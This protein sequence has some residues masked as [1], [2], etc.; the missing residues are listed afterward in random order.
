MGLFSSRPKWQ[1]LPAYE[2]AEQL[3]NLHDSGKK[4][5]ADKMISEIKKGKVPGITPKEQ[6]EMDKFYKRVTEGEKGYKAA[7]AALAEIRKSGGT[8]NFRNIP[9]RERLHPAA[10]RARIAS[11]KSR[12]DAAEAARLK[13]EDPATYQA[14][15]QAEAKRR[16]LI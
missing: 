13:K 8:K 15:L 5:E 6:K 11:G 9:E 14:L 2:I 3:Q 12:P 1:S 7:K 4:G 10:Y 16:G